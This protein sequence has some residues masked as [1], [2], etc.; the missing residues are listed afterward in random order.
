MSRCARLRFP[1]SSD[2]KRSRSA[3]SSCWRRRN[4]VATSS[5]TSCF[6]AHRVWEKQPW[7]TS[8]PARRAPRCTPPPG[9]RSR[10]RAISPASS[11]TSRKAISFSSTRSTASTPPSRNISTRPWRTTGWTSSSIPALRPLHPDQ[12]PALHP[13]R[14]DHPF[15]NA[16]R[17]AAL[18]FRSHQP[19]RLL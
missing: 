19:A 12:S 11:R 18:P 3:S 16:H 14:R 1:S 6:P 4:G 13:R 17:S 15:W 2:R 7:P 8:S 10:K 9:H 5:T